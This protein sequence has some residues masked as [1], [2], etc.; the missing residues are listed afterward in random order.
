MKDRTRHKRIVAYQSRCHQE[1]RAADIDANAKA[2][3]LRC[4]LR[5]TTTFLEIRST[6]GLVMPNHPLGGTRLWHLGGKP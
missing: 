2:Y 3:W 6:V 1:V 5:G 4:L